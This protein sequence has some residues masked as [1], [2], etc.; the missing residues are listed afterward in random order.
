MEEDGLVA[1]TSSHNEVWSDARRR[2]MKK[3][4]GKGDNEKIKLSG[5]REKLAHFAKHA[6]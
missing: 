4:G 5:V 6:V 1:P 3:R 2:M